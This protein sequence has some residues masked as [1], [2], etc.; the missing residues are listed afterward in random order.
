M[1]MRPDWIEK[2]MGSINSILIFF[3]S[4][5]IFESSPGL[6]GISKEVLEIFCRVFQG[7]SGL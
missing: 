1:V 7:S 6:N 3:F 4:R 5:G 2:I